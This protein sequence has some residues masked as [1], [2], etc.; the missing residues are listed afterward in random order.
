M[1]EL[2]GAFI[3]TI[4]GFILCVVGFLH[5]RK[6][7][8]KKP[9]PPIKYYGLQLILMLLAL[10]SLSVFWDALTVMPKV[11]KGDHDTVM[12][13]CS[14]EYC[15]TTMSLSLLF[16]GDGFINRVRIAQSVR[17]TWFL[18]STSFWLLA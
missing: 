9:L 14:V 1:M 4:V 3:L 13:A 7:Q 18:N 11:I 2:L 6:T 8:K 15:D 17:F 16:K 5:V 10:L 12:G